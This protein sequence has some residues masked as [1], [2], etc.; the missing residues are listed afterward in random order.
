MQKCTKNI[1]RNSLE[2]LGYVETDN[3]TYVPN[4]WII[5]DSI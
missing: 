3:E 5:K 2:I 1:D 4:N